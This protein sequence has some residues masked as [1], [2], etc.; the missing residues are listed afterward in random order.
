MF[1]GALAQDSTPAAELRPHLGNAAPA[2]V[3]DQ[4]YAPFTELDRLERP[5]PTITVYPL[6]PN[7]VGR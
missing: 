4:I 5:G 6:A 3:Y 7:G 2:F 1:Y